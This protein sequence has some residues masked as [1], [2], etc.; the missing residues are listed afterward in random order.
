ME[1]LQSQEP[2]P[3]EFEE[4]PEELYRP[5]L[6]AWMS[7]LLDPVL[8]VSPSA[9]FAAD[10]VTKAIVRHNLLLGQSVPFDGPVRITHTFNTGSAFGLFPDQTLFLIL[11]SFVGI[12]VLLVI[13]G[14]HAFQNLPLRLSLGMQLGGAVGNL[15]DRVRT[16]QV[17]DFMDVGP[18]PVFNVADAA[19]VIGMV[20]IAY[21]FLFPA[22]RR[23]PV[24]GAG[25]GI[26][27]DG[28][29]PGLPCPICD[30]DMAEVPHGRRCFEC[31]AEERVDGNGA[32]P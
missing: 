20:I 28:L 3:E 30:S 8:L 18:W 26:Y 10:Q 25:T 27:A 13:Y 2:G 31:G 23:T 9:V 24:P 4:E 5:S 14:T 1:K 15:F 22:S 6:P 32:G 12:G 16:G 19:I 29:M 11:A 21:V 7:W 17:T